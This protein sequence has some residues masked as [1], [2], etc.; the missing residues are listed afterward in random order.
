[1]SR[2]KNEDIGKPLRDQRIPVMVTAEEKQ[3]LQAAA[4]AMGVG[5]STYARLVALR[6][7]QE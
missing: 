6:D 1:M 4:A 7:A 5:V 2:P 3:A